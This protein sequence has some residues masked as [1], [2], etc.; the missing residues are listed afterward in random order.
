LKKDK[1]NLNQQTDKDIAK[2]NAIVISHKKHYS[3]LP[4]ILVFIIPIALY[5]QTIGFG[6]TR[7]DD[8]KIISTNLSF[9][10]NF[11]IRNA[12]ITPAFIVKGGTFYRPLQTLTYMIET[13]ITN[14]K[15]T[16]IFH[17]TNIF[18]LGLIGCLLLLLLEKFL[19][20][21]PLALYGTLI[22][23][24]HPLFVSS[25]A[26][27]P[28]RGDLLL[29]LCS[30]LSFIFLIEYHKN[31][32]LASLI[33][34]WLVFTL[35][36]FCKETALFLPILFIA[37]LLLFSNKNYFN[38]QNVILL[39]LYAIS[40]TL[41]FAIR[42][43]AINNSQQINHEIGISSFLSNIQTI[44]E[45]I[46]T[47]IYPLAVAP[48][49]GFTVFKTVFG[50]I[51]IISIFLLFIMTK[52]KLS[53]VTIFGLL[54]FIVLIVPPM[55]YKHPLIDYLDHRFFLPLI[56]ILLFLLIN[57]PQKWL[58]NS[59]FTVLCISLLFAFCL[60]TFIK[61]KAYSN[62]ISF[63]DATILQN[64]NSALAFNNRGIIKS[65]N[66]DK[67][68]A[69][70][71]FSTAIR[72]NNKYVEAFYN[73]GITKSSIGEKKDAI[74]D[75]TE[76]ISIYPIH[77]DAYLNR[78]I[79]KS[80]IGDNKGAID[81]YNKVLE[82]N[83]KSY[84]AYCNR[85]VSKS[86]MGN[87][88]NAIDDFTVAI[89]IE[90]QYSIAYYNRGISEFNLGN[91]TAAIDDYNKAIIIKPDYYQAYYQKGNIALSLSKYKEAIDDFDKSI[92]INPTYCNSFIKKGITMGYLGDFK[93]AIVAFNK[94]LTINPNSPEALNYSIYA[95]FYTKDYSG[96]LQDCEKALI[97]NPNDNNAKNIKMKVLQLLHNQE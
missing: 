15:G 27:I 24:A 14:S 21:K 97:L 80:D 4:F 16:W 41:W 63:Y 26:W 72:L 7:F 66:D 1:K 67:R 83:P 61:S 5:F 76:A 79:A 46:A 17:L 40:V 30:L 6:F 60:T 22:F 59:K 3:I 74:N 33:I 89:S 9:L 82:I 34:H 75:F 86:N 49:P 68:G 78:G 95:K 23:C 39:L 47:F 57:F 87:Y 96:T 88:R 28:A 84:T 90:S 38:K 85:G 64:K 70:D 35:A 51:L 12:F 31:K 62:P 43:S 11:S 91:I 81:D 44:P 32:K 18:I 69:I 2:G 36:L 37:Y 58:V 55:I 48:I 29:T 65:D 52:G 8:D 56:G 42:S 45:A 73:N 19:I 94:A 20:P 50:I 53:K 10:R 54:W 13:F 92:S 71:D 77:L 93:N 25:I